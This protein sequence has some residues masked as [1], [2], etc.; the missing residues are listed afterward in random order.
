[1]SVAA[2]LK[3]LRDPVPLPAQ[4]RADGIAGVALATALVRVTQD[5]PAL[6]DRAWLLA[7]RLPLPHSLY[8]L[9][10]LCDHHPSPARERALLNYIRRTNVSR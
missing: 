1:M 8:A 4:I 2:I 6:V 5:S 9:R 7:Y 3:L 10:D